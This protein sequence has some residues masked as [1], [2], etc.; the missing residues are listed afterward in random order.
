MVLIHLVG[1]YQIEILHSYVTPSYH[2][3]VISSF[4]SAVLWFRGLQTAGFIGY[5]AINLPF[6]MCTWPDADNLCS[7]VHRLHSNWLE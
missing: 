4:R 6:M 3:V 2:P 1:V 7:I 5:D